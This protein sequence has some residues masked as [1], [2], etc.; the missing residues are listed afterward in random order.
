MTD[1]KR[2]YLKEGYCKLQ[3]CK[4][5]RGKG[6]LFFSSLLSTQ[7]MDLEAFPTLPSWRHRSAQQLP[8]RKPDLQKLVGVTKG[9]PITSWVDLSGMYE[10]L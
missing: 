8:V 10:N 6:S 9:G 7:W 1:R 2:I 4:L 5:F 3:E